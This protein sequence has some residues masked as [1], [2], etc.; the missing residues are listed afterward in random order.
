MVNVRD[1]IS[2][3][4][5]Y[6][7][8]VLAL[9]FIVRVGRTYGWAKVDEDFKDMEPALSRGHYHWIDKTARTPETLHH[10]DLVMFRRPPWKRANWDYEF[11]RVIGLPG[12]VVGLKLGQIWRADRVKGKLS[13]R[14]LL[15]E[16]YTQPYHRPDDFSEFIV[17][18][19]TLF[20]MFDQRRRR[21]PLRELIVP[22]RA[23]H[24]RVLR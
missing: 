9:M 14:E 8:L 2:S 11:G 21:P 16:H 10:N 13:D 22:A 15:A 5:F 24:G 6:G 12:D 3:V 23:I 19:N 4:I 1:V 20:V 7:A 18:E 17:P